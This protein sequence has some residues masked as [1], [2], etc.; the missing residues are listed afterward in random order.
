MRDLLPI[1]AMA[2]GISMTSSW[3]SAEVA[4][5]P[6]ASAME[7]AASALWDQAARESDPEKRRAAFANV[8]K[9]YEEAHRQSPRFERIRTAASAWKNAGDDVKAANALEESLRHSPPAADR[10]ET[11]RLLAALDRSLARLLVRG[12]SGARLRD[13]GKETPLPAS[14]RREAGSSKIE[15][16]LEDGSVDDRTVVLRAGLTDT[17]DFSPARVPSTPAPPS[18]VVSPDEGTSALVITGGVMLGA[19]IA[20]A[21][22][23]SVIAGFGYSADDEAELDGPGSPAIEDAIAYQRAAWITGTTSAA[24]GLTGA[25]LL[26]VDATRGPVERTSARLCPGP[27][28]GLAVCGRF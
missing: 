26:V 13:E 9:T 18:A 16:I 3:A 8:A 23:T 12:P 28:T 19:G 10:E 17:L 15:I 4:N 14:L 7:A 6:A 27:G 1:L 2:F 11:E 21:I 22:A 25:L 24:V 20:G 5:E